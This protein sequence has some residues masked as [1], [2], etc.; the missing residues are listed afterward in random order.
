MQTSF[1]SLHSSP[2]LRW[3]FGATRQASP[4]AVN[5]EDYTE[6]KIALPTYRQDFPGPTP[7]ALSSTHLSSHLLHLPLPSQPGEFT[8]TLPKH[9]PGMA[10]LWHKT[11][12]TKRWGQVR[13][14]VRTLGL[15]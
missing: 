4:G 6:A 15:V 3:G 7:A 9:C 8:Q 11:I 14:C 2:P 10:K 13:I 1:L 5:P 12:G